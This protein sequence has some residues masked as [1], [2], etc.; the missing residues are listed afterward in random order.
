[1]HRVGRMVQAAVQCAAE[2]PG[3]RSA[4]RWQFAIIGPRQLF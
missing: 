2:T 1:M 3:D 4:R